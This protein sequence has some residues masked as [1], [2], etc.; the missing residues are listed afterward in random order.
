M[1]DFVIVT[2][3]GDDPVSAFKNFGTGNDDFTNWFFESVNEIH[4]F[5]LRKPPEGPL[6][7]LV[8]DS[9]ESVLQN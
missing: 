5:D 1:G 6:P 2:L 7:E 3:E 8:V 4:G 9:M